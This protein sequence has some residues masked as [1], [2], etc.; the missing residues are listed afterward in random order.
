MPTTEYCIKSIPQKSY[1]LCK[2]WWIQRYW[3][4]KFASAQKIAYGEYRERVYLH[5]P[6][7]KFRANQ[8]APGR[9][10]RDTLRDTL[11]DTLRLALKDTL[12][13]TLLFPFQG[14]LPGTHR[15][16]SVLLET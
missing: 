10:L 7:S 11:S 13:I 3:I 4:G 9:A 1:N 6:V 14:T 15:N 2:H 5:P 16:R 12:H 8:P